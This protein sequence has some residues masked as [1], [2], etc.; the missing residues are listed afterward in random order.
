MIVFKLLSKNDLLK[1]DKSSSNLLHI[2][3]SKE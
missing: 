2:K 3:S 1:K